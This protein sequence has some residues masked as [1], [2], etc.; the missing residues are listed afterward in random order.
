[1]AKILTCTC[2]GSDVTMP[3][4]HNG[5]V[6]GY[7]CIKKVAPAQKQV[8]LKFV[9]AEKVEIIRSRPTSNGGKMYAVNAV[10]DGKKHFLS[11]FDTQMCEQDGVTFIREDVFKK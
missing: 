7:T 2:C 5:M 4:F 6:Y 9:A 3:Q 11:V 8:K 1:M 10:V